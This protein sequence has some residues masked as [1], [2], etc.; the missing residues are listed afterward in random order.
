MI[1]PRVEDFALEIMQGTTLRFG[2][3]PIVRSG[4][5]FARLDLGIDVNTSNRYDFPA[6]LYSAFG[7]EGRSAIS[8]SASASM[9]RT[10][11]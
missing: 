1:G 9:H 10:S 7:F 8:G 5:T 4:R 11:P 3:S 2:V 6:V